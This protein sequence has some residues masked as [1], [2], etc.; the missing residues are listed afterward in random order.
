MPEWKTE[1]K[2]I[3]IGKGTCI[4]EGEEIAILTIG[5][6]GN[7]IIELQKELPKNMVAHYNMRFVKPLDV[8]L[9]H[10]IF[11]KFKT[12]VTYLTKSK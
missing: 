4:T 10:T 11:A 8:D 9:L 7:R 3:E 1:M 5:T 2:E 6:I 12:I